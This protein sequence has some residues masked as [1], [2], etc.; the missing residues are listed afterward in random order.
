LYNGELGEFFI[1]TKCYN[2]HQINENEM[3]VA[4]GICGKVENLHAHG[5][6]VGLGTVA[7]GCGFDS[8][9]YHWNISLT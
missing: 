3:E 1:L 8:Q 5:G 2:G 9:R 4:C 7:E 6:A